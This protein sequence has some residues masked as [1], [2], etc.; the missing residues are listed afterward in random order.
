[1][2]LSSNLYALKVRRLEKILGQKKQ[3]QK[4]RMAKL[5]QFL[6]R[7]P[8]PAFSAKVQRGD[9]GKFFKNHPK[10]SPGF[11]NLKALA[12]LTLSSN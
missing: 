9:E 6:K 12:Q 10:S 1:M 5:W 8:K 4:G 7:H 3:L 11:K 2:E